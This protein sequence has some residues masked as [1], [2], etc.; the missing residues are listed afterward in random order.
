MG[1]D[2]CVSFVWEEALAK[3]EISRVTIRPKWEFSAS[4]ELATLR[5][6]LTVRI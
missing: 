1:G 3:G 4:V 6:S 5:H 2:N